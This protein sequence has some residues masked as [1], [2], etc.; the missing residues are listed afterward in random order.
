MAI[1]KRKF[2][3]L[4]FWTYPISFGSAAISGEGGGYGF[5][6]ISEQDALSLLNRAFEL[7]INVYDTA[8]IYGYGLAE[9]RIGNAFAKKR[10]KVFIV[11]KGGVTWHQNQ[12]VNMTNDPIVMERMLHQSLDNLQTDYI[13]L[14]MVHWPDPAVD[15]RKPMKVL[16]K[17][18][19]EGKIRAIGLCNTTEEDL[20]RAMEVDKVDVV[21]SEFN[22]FKNKAVKEL[23]PIFE[24]HQIGFMSWGTL[25]KGILSGRVKSDERKFEKT[26]ARSWAPWWKSENREPKYK[27]MEKIR[28][29]LCEYGHNE[30]ALALAFNLSFK[31]LST[32]LCGCRGLLQLEEVVYGLENL[33]NAEVVKKAAE[34]VKTFNIE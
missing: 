5:G 21:Q 10:E 27:A 34:I 24:E 4:D 3:S 30:L 6:S 11:S 15:I 14:Y 20:V 29:M 19:R 2:G 7:G 23:F 25:D 31:N 17:A 16:S 9:K 32:A 13:D 28:L 18:K 1:E 33:P 22:L 12:R 8:P 26:D